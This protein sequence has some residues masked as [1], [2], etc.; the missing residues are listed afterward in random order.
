MTAFAFVIMVMGEIGDATAKTEEEALNLE[1]T[2]YLYMYLELIL[3]KKTRVSQ[4]HST[5]Q[6]PEKYESKPSRRGDRTGCTPAGRDY[7]KMD[8]N[9]L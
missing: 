9:R 2:K 6:R 3:A 1:G 7:S 8:P 4:S 5:N